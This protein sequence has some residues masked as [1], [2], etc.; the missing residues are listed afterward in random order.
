MK[1]LRPALAFIL[2][3][4][5]LAHASAQ[6]PSWAKVTPAD[7]TAAGIDVQL[8]GCDYGNN[9]FVLATYFGGSNAVPAIT[10]AVFTSPD[11]T[12]WTRRTLPVSGRTGA[13]RFLNG[14][15][16]LGVTPASTF[17]GN[18]VI[19]SSADGITWTASANLGSTINGPGEFAFGNGV[20]AAPVAANPASAQMLTSTDGNT[21][22]AR[23]IDTGASS[24]HITFFSGKFYA[25]TYNRSVAGDTGK[26]FSSADG[27]TWTRVTGAPSGPG[28]VAG[29]S[30]AL[31]VST[32]NG[33]VS[34]QAV[35]ADGAAFV[36][37]TPGLTLATE[38]IKFLNGA[39]VA[40]DSAVSG[41][42][43]LTVARASYDGRTWA[44][45]GSTT[46][47]FYATEVAYGNGRYVF[48]G[49]FDVFSGTTTVTP[50][51]VA[52]VVTTPTTPP[53]T[54]TGGTTTSGSGS[55]TTTTGSG[56]TGTTTTTGTTSVTGGK[57]H[58]G[59]G[60]APSVWFLAALA[61]LGAGRRYFRSQA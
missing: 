28:I 27:V 14:K 25:S 15:F 53:T 57:D 12:T 44:A 42:F 43:D 18:G 48:V 41:S 20:Y 21:W 61:L 24:S 1:L 46:N 30:A 33:S 51:G 5:C 56:G 7:V 35:S 29:G 45:I 38:T 9:L 34:G 52:P 22:T 32:L 47:A 60:G 10:P 17:G 31:L 6:A 4:A 40:T 16:L 55:T 26:L 3:L 59:H 11:G 54:T 39:F 23:V 13:P 8:T 19:L 50:G 36:T 37:A 2:A 49:E 58:S